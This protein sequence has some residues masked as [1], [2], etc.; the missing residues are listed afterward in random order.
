MSLSMPSDGPSMV[1]RR[2]GVA[3][4]KIGAARVWTSFWVSSKA[5]S[6]GPIL[7][8][9]MEHVLIR[10]DRAG[11]WIVKVHMGVRGRV[12]AIAVALLVSS[13]GAPSARAG[14]GFNPVNDDLANAHDL[15]SNPP[16]TFFADTGQFIGA[17]FEIG[18]PAHAGQ[19]ANHSVWSKWTAP[20]SGAITVSACGLT[21]QS[22]D[23]VLAVY[24]GPTNAPTYSNIQ[25]VASN[26]DGCGPSKPKLS[27]LKF[28]AVVGTTYYVVF[29]EVG[30][31]NIGT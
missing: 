1:L 19:P 4:A 16:S 6:I 7:S 10:T 21:N 18:E 11:W 3:R 23:S 12:L 20:Q 8:Q 9:E 28:N 2:S 29:D 13:F 14:G 26:D 15:N 17:T 24:S 22:I 5:K 27:K 30:T 25:P 31:S